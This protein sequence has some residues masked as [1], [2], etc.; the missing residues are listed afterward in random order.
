[1]P[2]KMSLLLIVLCLGLVGCDHAT[3]HLALQHLRGR[4]AVKMISGVFDLTYVENR[5]TAFSALRRI[6]SPVR[7]PLMKILGLLA[8]GV[9]AFLWY[10]RRR[11]ASRLEHVAFAVLL[12]GAI[13]NIADRF[14]RGYVIDFLHLRYWPVFNVADV[15]LVLGGLGVALVFWRS[16]HRTA[17]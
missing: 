16:Q 7:Q 4:A 3:K 6:P 1:M 17:S 9:Y 14:L 2:R 13:G 11:E 8:I 12:A 5:D 10:R 15:C